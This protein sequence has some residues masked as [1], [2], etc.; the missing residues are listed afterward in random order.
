M[1]AKSNVRTARRGPI[2]AGGY[3]RSV[4]SSARS[5]CDE[6]A[7]HQ[8][9]VAGPRR[10]LGGDRLGHVR[11]VR[12]LVEQERDG[13]G[14]RVVAREQQRHDLVADVRVREPRAVLVL[15][16][17]QQRQQVLTART[18]AATARDLAEDQPVEPAA[19]VEQAG[20]RGARP[21][22]DLEPVLLAVEG[23]RAL[24]L[25]RGV[26]AVAPRVGVQPEQRA[27]RDAQRQPAR[28][29]VDVDPVARAPR[30]DRPP[31]LLLHRRE[32]G[33]DPVAVEGG[34]HD[35]PRA[36]VELAVDREQAVA[37]QRDQV[38]EAAVAPREVGRVR[39]EDAV[40][41]GRAEHEH[42]ARREHAQAEHGPVALV[43]VE[44]QA[45][46]VRDDAMR[47]AH[48]RDHVAGRERGGRGELGAQVV[49]DAPE[50][51]RR[52]GRR[53]GQ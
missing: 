8:V 25:A 51:V 4:S 1:P 34:Q 24:E 31:D 29:G 16:V 17:E 27:H 42:H 14:R 36:P 7:A 32:R 39:D 38:G 44:Q 48:A 53:A 6:A 49:R 26:E 2:Q 5:R 3:S 30:F 15:G 9:L 43:G 41:R 28:P 52:D 50:R 46:R 33:G 12:E 20:E 21:A 19:R 10:Q 13:R 47:A 11:V 18:A 23:E 40:V 37:E 45:E 22:Q 35:P